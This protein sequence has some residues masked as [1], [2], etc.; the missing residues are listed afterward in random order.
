MAAIAADRDLLFGLLALQNGLIDQVQLVAAFQAWTRDKARALADHLIGRGDLDAD[1]RTA[2]EALVARHLKKHGG[3]V[4]RSLA[5]IPVGRSTRESLARIDDPDVGGTLA[6]LGSASTQND[7]DADRTASYAVGEATSEGQR[8]RILRPHARGGLGAVFVALDAEL[9]REV[10]LKQI[11]DAHADDPV[12]RQR[13]LLEAE[14]TGG[15]EHPGI[16]PVYGL[17]TYGDGRPFYAMRFIRGDSLKE[18]IEHFHAGASLQDDR[19]GRSLELRKLLRRFL[20]VCNAIEYAHARGVLHRDIKPGNIIVG[21]HGETLVV[22]WGLAKPLGHVEP[23]SDAG[24]RTLRPSAASGSAETLPGSALG[25]PAYMSPEQA[26]GDLERLGPRSDVYSLGATLYCLLTGQPPFGGDDVGAVLRGVQSGDLRRPRHLDPTIDRALEAVCLKAMAL[27][28]EDR[29]PSPKALSDDVERWMADEPVTAWHEPA[30]VRARRWAKRHRP[31]MAAA[32]AATLMA[33]TGLSLILTVQASANGRLREANRQLRIA[34][35]RERQARDLAQARYDLARQAVAA[36]YTG[37]SEDV[38]LKQPQLGELRSK[39]LNT[40]LEFYRKLQEVL[41]S[42]GSPSPAARADLAEACFRIGSIGVEV[43]SKEDALTA[44]QEALAIREALARARPD[45]RRLQADLA[46]SH[47]QIGLVHRELGQPDESWRSHRRALALRESLAKV[48]PA[49]LRIRS[50]LASSLLESGLLQFDA[51]QMAD[52]MTSLEGARDRY[53]EL[54][55]VQPDSVEFQAQKAGCQSRIALILAQTGRLPD[56]LRA[57]EQALAIRERLAAANPDVTHLQDELCRSL[58]TLVT[59]ELQSGR[60]ARAVE[61]NRRALAIREA[62]ARAHPTTSVFQA[63]LARCHIYLAGLHGQAA[64]PAEAVEA[65]RRAE[66]IL[67]GLIR[68]NPHVTDYRNLLAHCLVNTGW[69]QSM[70]GR[71]SDALDSLRRAETLY[72]ALVQAN[73]KSTEFRNVLALT[74]FNI[75]A[76]LEKTGRPAESLDWRRRPLAIQDQMARDHPTVTRYQADRAR[77]LQAIGFV[78]GLLGRG[79]EALR[80]CRQALEIWE[81]LA[82]ANP[83]EP[84]FQ[85]ALA[86]AHCALADQHSRAG[87]LPE[88]LR[89][90]QE[91]TEIRERLVTEHPDQA[92]YSERLAA[93]VNDLGR[94][95]LKHGHVEDAIRSYRKALSILDR[96]DRD[97]PGIFTLQ[98][99]LGYTYRGLGRCLVRSGRGDEALKALQQALAIDERYSRSQP[100]A[101][102]D[103]ACDWALCITAVGRDGGERSPQP[104]DERRRLSDRA[105]EALREAIAAGYNAVEN[106][107]EDPDLDPL[108]SRLDFQALLLDLIFPADPFSR[109]E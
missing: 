69:V 25:T 24:E 11:L 47:Y 59:Y 60:L 91:A 62:V 94:L 70:I 79:S 18:A 97:H 80:V 33:V 32:A 78:Q 14:V 16:V 29:Y 45:D 26:R 96:F 108:R 52:A 83:T 76:V 95:Q 103:L 99:Q 5:A 68:S 55:A 9:H 23:G 4:E 101:R 30:A 66:A 85:E 39:L 104:S 92:T 17:G 89:M 37:A 82:A 98:Q 3:D 105:M 48:E 36:Y 10:A 109:G 35:G 56:A 15:L 38:L 27:K 31:L 84:E 51:G 21:R 71:P 75:G 100:M 57:G 1:D 88:A 67:K 81:R 19:G 42:E 90:C 64:R 53:G 22:D 73:P 93:T 61:A 6:Q 20:D 44:H 28:P 12:S 72:E 41:E 2:V 34:N 46:R 107:K 49:D 74:R 7:H 58:E 102:Y 87:Q 54:L 8:F 63:D 43:G 40:A 65:Y 77:S 106:L 86:G 13:F 50:E